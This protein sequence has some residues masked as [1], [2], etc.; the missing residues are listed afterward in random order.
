MAFTDAQF[1]LLL[2]NPEFKALVD[3]HGKPKPGPKT[4]DQLNDGD[5]CME[6]DCNNGKKIVMKCRGNECVDYSEVDCLIEKP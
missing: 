2:Q 4:C 1:Q 5:I 6:T 3:K